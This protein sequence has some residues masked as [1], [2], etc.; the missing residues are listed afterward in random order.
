MLTSPTRTSWLA[1][2]SIARRKFFAYH[3]SVTW[4]R[5]TDAGIW[6]HGACSTVTPSGRDFWQ[7]I[8][9]GCGCNFVRPPQCLILLTALV[10]GSHYGFTTRPTGRDWYAGQVNMPSCNDREV[11]VWDSSM[12]AFVSFLNK[13]FLGTLSSTKLNVPPL[14][15]RKCTH[16]CNVGRS[17]PAKED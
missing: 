16:A 14:R 11:I 2:D 8:W 7:M 6:F 3:D 15:R 17:L 9:I 12:G 4:A 13:F 10:N 5:C 1:L